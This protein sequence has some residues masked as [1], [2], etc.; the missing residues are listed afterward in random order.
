MAEWKGKSRG[1][2]LGYSIF[3]FLFKNF[4]VYPA[5]FVLYFVVLY[6]FFFSPETSRHIYYFFNKRIGYGTIKSVFKIYISYYRLGQML[7]DKVMIMSGMKDK[8]TSQSFGAENLRAIVAGNKGGILLGAH[9]GN[10]EIA[11]H[12][13]MNYGDTINILVYDREHEQIKEYLENVT[14]GRKFKLIPIKDDLSHIYEIGEALGRN[15][16]IATTADRFLADGK[17]RSV[18]FLGEEA[19][20]PMGIFQI[21]KTFRANYSFVYGIKCSATHYNF[22]CRP[23]RTVTKE[24]TIDMI[25]EDYARD[26]E[27]MVRETPDQWFNYYDFW[28]KE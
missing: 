10:W 26:L 27:A 1:N 11:G 5:Y 25:L 17:T 21:I 13:L 3:V 2:K 23:H 12:Y 15:E 22:Y 18:K 7:I 9:L 19:R 14:G 20:F 4:G 28:K 8:F 16:I 24:T 6:Y